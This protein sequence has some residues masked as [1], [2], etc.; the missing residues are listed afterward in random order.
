[1]KTQSYSRISSRTRF[2]RSFVLPGLV[3]VLGVAVCACRPQAPV[4]GASEIS[5]LYTLIGVGGHTVPATLDHD[6]AK[7]Q[8]RS[9]SMTLGADGTCRSTMVFVPP[10]GVEAT[11]EVAASFTREGT[12]L[13][14]QWQ[15]AGRTTG[16]ITG[17]TFTMENEGM[18]FV[19]RKQP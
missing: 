10:S 2:V 12:K 4:G 1:M 15:G 3:L 5:G 9:G 7:L 6:G 11:R 8:V 17:D 19:Y 14:L 16:Y 13:D 18:E